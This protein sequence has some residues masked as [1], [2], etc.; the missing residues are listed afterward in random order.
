MF[1]QHV[2]W[3]I[4]QAGYHSIRLAPTLCR[5]ERPA[6]YRGSG[7]VGNG[8]VD[9]LRGGV[10]DEDPLIGAGESSGDTDDLASL[11][12]DLRLHAYHLG[13]EFA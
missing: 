5:L 9:R 4:D 10:L 7:I 12:L 3:H 11:A 13:F 2:A 6:A 1:T 8:V